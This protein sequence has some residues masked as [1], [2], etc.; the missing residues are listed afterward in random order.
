[1]R[2][3]YAARQPL[4]LILHLVDVLYHLLGLLSSR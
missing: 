2:P 1:L 3:R 4:E